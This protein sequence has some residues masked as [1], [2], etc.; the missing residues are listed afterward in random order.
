MNRQWITRVVAI[1]VG[2]AVVFGLESGL[3][4]QLY[5]AVPIAAVAYLATLVGV[6]LILR[7]DAP[8]K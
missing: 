7:A 8:Q 6:G 2:A 1:A 5:F 4:L 3:G